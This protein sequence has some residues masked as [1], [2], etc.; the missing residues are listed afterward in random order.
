M[1]EYLRFKKRYSYEAV[2]DHSHPLAQEFALIRTELLANGEDPGR[3]KQQ[4]KFPVGTGTEGLVHLAYDKLQHCI[5]VIKSCS[6]ASLHSAED[7]LLARIDSSHVIK[8]SDSARVSKFNGFGRKTHLVMEYG[9]TSLSDLQTRKVKLPDEEIRTM[10][11]H[12]LFGVLDSL[13][14][15]IAPGDM[16][17]GNLVKGSEGLKMIDFGKALDLSVSQQEWQSQGH[18]FSQ[19]DA[20][21]ACLH[22]TLGLTAA[23][24]QIFGDREPGPQVQN[25]LQ[26]DLGQADLEELVQLLRDHP[27]IV[28]EP[29]GQGHIHP[30]TDS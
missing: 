3:G 8:C 11:R 30:V 27:F 25:Y 6:D 20:A 17:M 23:F 18:G 22:R 24:Y 16:K 10:A 4:A 2:F 14:A 7:Q 9:G 15:G 5:V 28:N 19:T 1:A 12:L 13:D 26:R 29:T 21:R